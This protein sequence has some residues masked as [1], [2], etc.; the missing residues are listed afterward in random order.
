MNHEDQPML[1][2]N[3]SDLPLDPPPNH[4]QTHL[5]QT[6]HG[7]HPHHWLPNKFPSHMMPTCSWRPNKPDRSTIHIILLS[8][9]MVCIALQFA[10]SQDPNL[11]WSGVA[12]TQPPLVPNEIV[13]LQPQAQCQLFDAPN[14]LSRLFSFHP[15][16][17]FHFP[18]FSSYMPIS[19]FH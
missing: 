10:Q 15:Y 9:S 11:S 18:I 12:S 14:A 5:L 6:F 7:P 8:S 3:D 19:L 13:Y 16:W 2:P 1:Y 4:I 17:K